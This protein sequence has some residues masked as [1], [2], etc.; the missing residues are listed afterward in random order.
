MSTAD[1]RPAIAV[2]A[3]QARTGG[4]GTIFRDLQSALQSSHL[5]MPGQVPHRHQAKMS[6]PQ[7]ILVYNMG[8]TAH[9]L[10][11]SEYLPYFE[12]VLWN[13]N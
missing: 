6:R 8:M 5:G 2:T 1:S 13:Y 9:L 3:V 11:T 10:S 4:A 12:S 7:P